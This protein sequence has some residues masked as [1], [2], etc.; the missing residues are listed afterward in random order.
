MFVIICARFQESRRCDEPMAGEQGIWPARFLGAGQAICRQPIG[1][2]LGVAYRQHGM[3]PAFAGM[4]SCRQ[5]RALYLAA[6]FGGGNGRAIARHGVGGGVARPSGRW[7]QRTP[8]ENRLNAAGAKERHI[9][10]SKMKLNR[11]QTSGIDRNPATQE[12]L[13]LLRVADHMFDQ[14]D[15]FFKILFGFDLGFVEPRIAVR[16]R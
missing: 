13:E 9:L 15:Y 3:T 12:L 14:R 5:L 2:R 4:M 6:G 7:R 10:R 1:W 8:S 11:L 16:A